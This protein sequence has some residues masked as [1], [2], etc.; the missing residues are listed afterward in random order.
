VYVDNDGD[1]DMDD[2]NGDGRRDLQDA[3]WLAGVAE[4]MM[5]REP[6]LTPGGLSV[7]RRNPVHGPFLHVD[8]R[9]QRARW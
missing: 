1:G 2:L 6:G 9:G 3:R 5:A 8:A 7:Y 4:R